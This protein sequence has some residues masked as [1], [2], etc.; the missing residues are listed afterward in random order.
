MEEQTAKEVSVE[1]EER[2]AKL[3]GG[4]RTP[5]SGG[6]AWKKGDVLSDDWFAECKTTVKPSLSYSV[7]K[8][9]LDKAD[10]ERAEMHKQYGALA[11]TLGEDREDYFVINSRTLKAIISQQAAIR[12][13]ATRVQDSITEIDRRR[14]EMTRGIATL[15]AAEEASYSAHRAEKQAFLEEL[16]KMI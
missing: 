4:S 11:F 12:D 3:I 1:Q 6:G 16:E 2:V 9:V 15:S 7:N 14:A 13:L 8:A 5:R 10:H